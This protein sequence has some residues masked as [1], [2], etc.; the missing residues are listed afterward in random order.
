ML[1]PL[2]IISFFLRFQSRHGKCEPDPQ[3]W[4]NSSD[5]L[6]TLY[7]LEVSVRWYLCVIEFL[8]F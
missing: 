1:A 6:H 8:R 3:S 7:H 2:K 4:W 5:L